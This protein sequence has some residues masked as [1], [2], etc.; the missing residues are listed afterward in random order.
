MSSGDGNSVLFWVNYIVLVRQVGPCFG[1]EL[2][3]DLRSDPFKL[4]CSDMVQ[5][6]NKI[7]RNCVVN[8]FN[9]FLGS[10]NFDQLIFAPKKLTLNI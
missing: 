2:N 7:S 5:V 1:L 8:V 6:K 4:A 3:L 10:H 9:E